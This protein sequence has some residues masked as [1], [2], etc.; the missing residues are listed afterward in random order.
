MDRAHLIDWITKVH[1]AIEGL[2]QE[3]LHICVN[4]IDYVIMKEH[5]QYPRVQGLGL[6]ALLIASKFEDIDQPTAQFLCQMSKL[7]PISKQFGLLGISEPIQTDLI[8]ELET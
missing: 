1:N 4:I 2:K 6:T 7:I 5:V 3:T 8:K